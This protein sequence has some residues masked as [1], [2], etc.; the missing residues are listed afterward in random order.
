MIRKALVTSC[1][2]VICGSASI[3]Q[4]APP[5]KV[6]VLVDDEDDFFEAKKKAPKS[7]TDEVREHA[8]E[9]FDE[10]EREEAKHQ[11]RNNNVVNVVVV[12]GDKKETE[13]EAPSTPDTPDVPSVV[14]VPDRKL[15]RAEK[16]ALKHQERIARLNEKAERRRQKLELRQERLRLRQEELQLRADIRCERQAN[17]GWWNRPSW[18]EAGDLMVHGI[19]SFNGQG[20]YGGV[21]LEYLFTDRLGLRGQYQFMGLRHDDSPHGTGPNLNVTHGGVWANPNDVNYAQL[22]RGRIHLTDLSLAV[23][24]IARSRFDLYPTAGISYMNYGL[25]YGDHQEKGG[26]GYLRLGAG[27]NVVIKRF[28]A[29][30]EFG[31]YPLQL[32]RHGTD[33]AETNAV[34]T[35]DSGLLPSKDDGRTAEPRNEGDDD[36]GPSRFNAKRMTLTAHVGLRF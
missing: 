14:V 16:R 24:T 6:E 18:A 26:A 21:G 10:L 36:D 20:P 17:V 3:V 13:V 23:H 8:D 29:G 27:F 22:E 15:T 31:W 12:D 25:D 19:G 1:L 32:F 33:R 2:A 30:L 4:A 5:V 34:A 35:L 11:N 28:Y 9:M 7:R